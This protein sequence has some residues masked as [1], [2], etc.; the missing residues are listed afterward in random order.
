[1]GVYAIK[2]RF[3]TGLRGLEH[4]LIARGVSADQL[5]TAGTVFA[6]SAA[7]SVLLS[8]L[9]PA[10]LIAVTPLVLLRLTCNALD[11]MVAVDTR[12]AR[13]LGHVYNEFSDRVGDAAILT[14]VTVRTDNPWL[15]AAALVLVLL[16]SYLGTVA[17]AAGGTRQYIG[18]MGKA[19]RMVLLAFAAPLA[20]VVGLPVLND[21][22][23]LVAVG[24]VVTLTQRARAIRRELTGVAR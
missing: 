13:P 14:A 16:S 1:M 8:S 6:L 20:E 11:G 24:S 18:V 10:W 21:F 19:D 17:A 9:H 15:G 22:L 12:T 3:R 4:R 5:T 7:A 23:V 2:P